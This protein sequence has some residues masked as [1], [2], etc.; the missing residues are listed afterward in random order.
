M[1]LADMTRRASVAIVGEVVESRAVQMSDGPYRLATVTVKESLWGTSQASVIVASPGGPAAG[2][3][4][5]VATVI[6]GSPS[7]LVRE[8]AVLLLTA[9]PARGG[10][11]IVGFDQGLLSVTKTPRG[12]EVAL[13]GFARP[14][15]LGEATRK[16]REIRSSLD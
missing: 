6:A 4:F 8:R 1:T 5:P 13:P 2:A 10:Y 15:A 16:I 12:D 9:D 14:M 7:L 11:S 3:K